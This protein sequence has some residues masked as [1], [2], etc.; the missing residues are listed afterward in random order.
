MLSSII[1]YLLITRHERLRLFAL[2][3]PVVVA[4]GV[5]A[6][7]VPVVVADGVLALLVPVVVAD[8]VGFGFQS[9]LNA[10]ELLD[11]GGSDF[12][13]FGHVTIRGE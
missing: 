6:L 13:G 3:V 5:L 1:Y 12:S 11:G 2:L 9:G 10:H 8:G 4:D 7:L